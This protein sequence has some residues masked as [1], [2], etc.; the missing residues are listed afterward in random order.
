MFDAMFQ[1]LYSFAWA[2]M[3]AHPF[4]AATAANASMFILHHF[5]THKTP[6]DT[7]N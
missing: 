4:I 3:Y 2:N 7:A 6:N 1:F 5:L